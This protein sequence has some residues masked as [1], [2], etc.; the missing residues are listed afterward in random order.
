[1]GVNQV[2]A[3][4][5]PKKN[6]INGIKEAVNLVG[7]ALQVVGLGVLATFIIHKVGAFLNPST[8]TITL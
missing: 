8:E 1:V 5:K 6:T 7:E 4:R 3:T 2:R